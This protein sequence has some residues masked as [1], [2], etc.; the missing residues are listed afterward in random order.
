MKRTLLLC[1]L[2]LSSL[3]SVSQTTAT[4]QFTFDDANNQIQRE[5]VISSARILIEDET[6]VIE[7]FSKVSN[8]ENKKDFLKIYPNP[9]QGQVQV[10]ISPEIRE[11]IIEIRL[12]S[13]NG[14]NSHL[15][16]FNSGDEYVF[17]DLSR[18]ISGSYQLVARLSNGEFIVATIIKQ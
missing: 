16:D 10:W 8:E 11:Q 18:N 14:M 7:E 6:L 13:N 17:L 15:L 2:L 9:T 12:Y 4:L 3:L 5:L 1:L